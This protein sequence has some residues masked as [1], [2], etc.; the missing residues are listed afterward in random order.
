MFFSF[1]LL[2]IF[3]IHRLQLGWRWNWC[4]SL[5]VV[6]TWNMNIIRRKLGTQLGRHVSR[7]KRY[8]FKREKN[9]LWPC[10]PLKRI[11]HGTWGFWEAASEGWRQRSLKWGRQYQQLAELRGQ[12][13]RLWLDRTRYWLGI[14]RLGE[15]QWCRQG[16]SR[17]PRPS[18]A[19]ATSLFQGVPSWM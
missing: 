2:N 12:G 6:F 5:Q 14:W 8:W 13:G 4:A 15:E 19:S 16:C 1:T 7:L 18:V 11:C 9:L 3:L 17:L 10:Q